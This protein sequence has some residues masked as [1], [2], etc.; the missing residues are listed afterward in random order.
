MATHTLRTRFAKDIVAEFL[1]P[2]RKTKNAKAVIICGGMPGYGSKKE[3]LEFFSR[4]GYW[5]FQPRYR[6]SWESDGQFLKI[7][8]HQDV[9]DVIDQLPKGFKEAFRRRFYKVRPS[10]IYVIG[11]SFGGPAALLVSTDPRVSKVIAVSPVVDWRAPSKEEPL[12]PLFSYIREG[13]GNGYRLHKADWQK[14][15]RSK[16]YDPATNLDKIDPSKI[17]LVHAAD[18]DVVSPKSVKKFAAKT[19]SRLIM[20]KKGGHLATATIVEPKFYKRIQKFL[21]S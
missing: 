1:P 17:L 14:L 2:T 20:L 11:G 19:G 16:F 7:S 21:N 4:K 12:G 8:P 13:F 3:L 15:G 10:K 6:G 18:D 9:L 5:V